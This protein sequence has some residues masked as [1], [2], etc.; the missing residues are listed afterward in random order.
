MLARTYLACIEA[1]ATTVKRLHLSRP[2]SARFGHAIPA[3]VSRTDLHT[4]VKLPRA[5]NLSL[6][7]SLRC[8]TCWCDVRNEHGIDAT[9]FNIPFEVALR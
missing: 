4:V 8:H 1:R 6:L 3:K 9:L 7:L 5:F 2:R